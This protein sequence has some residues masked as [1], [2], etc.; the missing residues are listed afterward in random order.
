[1]G[2][3]AGLAGRVGFQPDAS[4]FLIALRSAVFHLLYYAHTLVTLI[5]VTPVFF[6]LPQ[7]ACLSVARGWARRSLWLLRTICG[8]RI[9]YEGTHRLPAGGYILAHKHQSE[10]DM[11]ALLAVIRNPAFIVK[12][13]LLY[14]PIWGLWAVKARMIFVS[15]GARSVA[16]EQITKGS[17]RALEHGRPVVI[18]PEGT[19]VRPGSE[20][21]YKYGVVHLYRQ[22]K[23]PV[24]P[25]ALN[26]GIYWPWWR[27]MRYPGTVTV[28][29]LE[30]IQPGLGED[31]FR[32]LLVEMIETECDRLLLAADGARPRP[33]FGPAAKARLA[34]IREA[35]AAE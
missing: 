29:F 34:A 27:F 28:S 19:R 14:I 20:P 6:F 15:R 18:A 12:R 7:P 4:R 8:L 1:M 23:V 24:V 33:G 31:E 17:R 5:A 3:D 9:R 21:A 30:P 16:L 32:P 10:L 35:S 25:A 11:V 13:E 2:D 22:L 26:T